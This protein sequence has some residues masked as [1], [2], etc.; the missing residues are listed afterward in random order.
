MTASFLTLGA[1]LAALLM[2]LNVGANNSAAEMGPAYGCGA[3]TRRQAVILIAVFT[4]LGAFLAGERVVHTL[5]S[6]LTG[7]EVLRGN[8]S[9][10]VI[11]LAAAASL[12]AVANFLRVP[13]P[14]SHIMV[15]AVSGIGL[16]FGTLNWHRLGEIVLWWLI[17]PLAALVAAY[18]ARRCLYFPLL[19][20]V[21]RLGSEKRA[22]AVIRALITL[23]GCAMAFSAGSNSLAK[24]IG[25]AVGAGV[26]SQQSGAIFGGLAMALGALLLGGR[27]METVGKRITQL[28]GVAAIMVE[29]ICASI[30]FS[31]SRFGVPVSLAE[32]VT[33][34]VVGFS[35]AGE[36]LGATLRNPSVR[37][38]YTLWP[39]CPASCAVFVL[40]LALLFHV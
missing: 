38:I 32:I 1:G 27:V 22:R 8:L 6:G 5:G 30:V 17:T 36:G 40:L 19:L 16:Y 4:V 29:V 28:C 31:A 12:V 9:A 11:A 24:A 3:R 25:P 35:V 23:S 33:S 26:F 39:V 13:I 2:A 20:W 7:G 18:L 15:G 21:S 10:V 34:A 37:R 14:T